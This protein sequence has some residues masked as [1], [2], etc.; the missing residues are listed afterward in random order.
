MQRI[1]ESISLLLALF[2]L[3]P[4]AAALGQSDLQELEQ[5][6]EWS[7][8]GRFDDALHLFSTI[9]SR[10]PN[11]PAGSFFLAAVYQSMMLDYESNRWRPLFYQQIERAILLAGEQHRQNP[12]DDWAAFFLGAAHVYKGSQQAREGK[13]FTALRAVQKGLGILRP[14]TKSDTSF[15]DPL[16]GIGTYDYW[17]SKLTAGLSW[18]PLFPDRRTEGIAAVEKSSQCARMSRWA[19]CSNLCWI[20]IKE[21]DYDRAAQYAEEGLKKFPNSRFFLWPLAEAQLKKKDLAAAAVSW[22]RL[23]TSVQN[24]TI[25]NHYNELVIRWKL[26]QCCEGTGQL[27]EA[28]KHCRALLALTLDEEVADRAR[29]R[30]KDARKMLARLNGEVADEP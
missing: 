28:R 20:F 23:L 13:Y 12:A 11:H 10:S 2:S 1:R 27:I 3:L 26:A 7:V 21:E 9:A 5:G 22:Q 8:A 25:N 14:L 29:G 6:I 19:A 4:A 24:D 17:R 16:L 18:L 30:K 15:C